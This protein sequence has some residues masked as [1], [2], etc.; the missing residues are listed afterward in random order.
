MIYQIIIAMGLL[1]FT[2]NAILNLRSL[3]SPSKRAKVPDPAPLVSILVP[4]RNEEL[5]IETCVKSLQQ[6]DY[7]NFEIVVLDDNST[8]NTAEIVSR[9]AAEDNRVRLIKGQPLIEN[10]AGKPFACYQLAQEARGSWYLFVD[11]D[12]I[13]APYMLR[14][15]L[16]LAM[17]LNTSLLSGFPRQ[18]ATGLA[19]KVAIPVPFYFF[20]ISTLPLWWLHRSKQPK[21][22]IAIGQFFLFTK[23]AYWQ[24]G[25]HRAVKSR[26]LEDVWLAVE[27]VKHGGRHIA[28]NL[29][30]VVYCN[31]YCNVGAMWE[32][33]IKWIHSVAALSPIALLG[34]VVAGYCFFLAPFYWLW[35][36]FIM[37]VPATDWRFIIA[38][39]VAL[40][41]FMRIVIGFYFKNSFI[42]APLHFFGFSFLFISALYSGWR[43]ALHKGIAWKD[44]VYEEVSGVK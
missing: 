22:S 25:G 24:V 17:E 7:P 28:V 12:T 4:A 20:L 10:W 23:E 42:S 19:Q 15:T 43:Q 31:M 40:I 1:L 44:R 41:F 14:S 6:Q 38:I 5:N 37:S 26:I 29:S 18:L 35:H 36:D 16:A 39:Q 33:F 8:D 32:G 27:V 11:A 21:P 9:I 13:H 3:R 2:I 30:N 34:L